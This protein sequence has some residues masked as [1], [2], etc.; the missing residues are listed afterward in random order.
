MRWEKGKR[1]SSK[2]SIP[3]KKSFK[4]HV[5]AV[6]AEIRKYNTDSTFFLPILT[7]LPQYKRTRL[8]LMSLQPIPTCSDKNKQKKYAGFFF[9]FAMLTSFFPSL[10]RKE[11]LPPCTRPVATSG[12]RASVYRNFP[13]FPQVV[14]NYPRK[15]R[16][17]QLGSMCVSSAPATLIFRVAM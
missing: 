10:L 3:I 8:T 17:E 4:R 1:G 13:R 2:D 15:G 6:T 12:L 5:D 16:V 7:F 9:F 11:S 14:P